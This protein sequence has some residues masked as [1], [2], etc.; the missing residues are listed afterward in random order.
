[1]ENNGV[2][3]EELSLV[4]CSPNYFGEIDESYWEDII[5]ENWDSIEDG[6]KAVAAKLKEFNEFLKTQ[7]PFSWSEGIYRT[8]YK[9]NDSIENP[10]LQNTP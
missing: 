4:I 10:P 8:E 3:P 7:P 2:L 9:P 6:N 5:P 1:M